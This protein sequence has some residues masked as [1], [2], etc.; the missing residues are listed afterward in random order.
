LATVRRLENIRMRANNWLLDQCNKGSSC[1]H[2]G[3]AEAYL[4]TDL[5]KNVH[6]YEKFGF[7]VRDNDMPLIENHMVPA[8]KDDY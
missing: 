4:E 6:F 8:K 5:D 1:L 3:M 2:T 7:K